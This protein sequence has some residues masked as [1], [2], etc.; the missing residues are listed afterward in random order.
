M[1]EGNKSGI[2]FLL[3]TNRKEIGCLIFD[4]MQN[5]PL[6]K[7][8]V[9]VMLYLQKLWFCEFCKYDVKTGLTNF[10]TYPEGVVNRGPDE[11]CS[12]LWMII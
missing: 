8:P 5:L 11:V 9:Q 4:Y 10:F 12:L 3:Q 1:E 6:L 2:Y 7:I